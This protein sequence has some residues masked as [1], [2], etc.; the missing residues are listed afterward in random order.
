[1]KL[2]LE[3]ILVVIMASI[4]VGFNAM[5]MTSAFCVFLQT[6]LT[7]FGVLYIILYIFEVNVGL[8]KLS[9]NPVLN[10]TTMGLMVISKMNRNF[11]LVAFA[12]IVIKSIITAFQLLAA[13]K[14]GCHMIMGFFLIFLTFGFLALIWFLFM[15]ISN[16]VDKLSIQYFTKKNLIP[17]AG[18]N[19]IISRLFFAIIQ[20]LVAFFSETHEVA[21]VLFNNIPLV[22]DLFDEAVLFNYIYDLFLQSR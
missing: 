12:A 17:I 3:I 8:G 14:L 5:G 13:G 4:F 16:K 21:N 19:I 22:S 1:M 9:V 6:V 11:I 10:K 7:G 15:F 20:S 2:V 18:L